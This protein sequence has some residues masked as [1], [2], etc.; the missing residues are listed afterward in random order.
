MRGLRHAQ[1][2]NLPVA[3]SGAQPASHLMLELFVIQHRLL[4]AAPVLT[5]LL[6]LKGAAT[7]AVRLLA[8]AWG[9]GSHEGI[10]QAPSSCSHWL[11]TN[12]SP[13]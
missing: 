7:H 11:L 12:A 1:V 4:T 10:L 6:L 8:C 3:C 5:W 2:Q 9:P 13:L